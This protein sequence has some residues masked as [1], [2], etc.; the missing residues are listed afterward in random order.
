MD[1]SPLGSSV[2]GILQ[3]R[4]LEW[5]AMPSCRGSSW[6]RAHTRVSEVTCIGRWVLY[7]QHHLEAPSTLAAAA[8]AA[9][10]TSVVSDSV[11]PH[12]QQPTRLPR[13]WDSPG[14]NTGMGCH[15]LLQC[16]QVKS[17]NEV[18]VSII[19]S[20]SLLNVIPCRAH[21]ILSIHS[22]VDER[23]GSWA[24]TK[25]LAMNIYGHPPASFV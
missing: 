5:V 9:S 2:H 19:P 17:E 8:A 6:S 15:L 20:F 25:N 22:P 21:L 24:I 7:H 16:M 10:V 12:R 3:A 13:P 11:R 1:C 14:K 4:I 23:V 18:H